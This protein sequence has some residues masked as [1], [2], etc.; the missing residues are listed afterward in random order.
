MYSLEI[1]WLASSGIEWSTIANPAVRGPWSP[2]SIF[3][4]GKTLGVHSGPDGLR[5]IATFE[6]AD[7]AKII[8]VSGEV[9]DTI[10]NLV[11]P[12]LTLGEAQARGGPISEDYARELYTTGCKYS[13][14]NPVRQFIGEDTQAMRDLNRLLLVL[15]RKADEEHQ[16]LRK[17]QQKCEDLL[18]GIAIA[19]KN[20]KKTRSDQ[21][22]SIAG[23]KLHQIRLYLERLANY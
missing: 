15:D 5:N 6:S 13:A 18:K 2:A 22:S 10:R 4:P 7:L 16:K 14:A 17:S 23:G 12:W 20:L 11:V 3:G 9:M 21:I 19:A 8:T 1:S